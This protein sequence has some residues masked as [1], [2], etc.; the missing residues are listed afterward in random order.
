MRLL[1]PDKSTQG[2]RER[3]IREEN[4]LEKEKEGSGIR[5]DNQQGPEEQGYDTDLYCRSRYI[6]L[7]VQ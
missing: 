5:A 2:C 4:H 7:R 1:D 6:L 3:K